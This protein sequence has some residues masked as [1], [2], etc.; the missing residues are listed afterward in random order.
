MTGKILFDV[1]KTCKQSH[2]SGVLRV[3]NC[4]K[5]ELKNALGDRLVEVVWSD[6]KQ[7]FKAPS[8]GSKFS[9][10]PE[11]VFLTAELFSDFE[12]PGI[13]AFL[14]SER[15]RSYA[16]FHDAIP[17]RHPE[18]TWPHSVQ[19]HPSYMK[20]LSRFDGVFAVSAHSSI[21]L[22]EYWEWLG[23]EYAPSVKS[24]QLGANGLFPDP[25][26]SS[27]PLVR[28]FDVLMLGIIEKRKGQDIALDAC[29]RLWDEGLEFNLHVVG[30]ANPYFGKD[31]EKRIK[32]MERNGRPVRLHGH[33]E[34]EALKALMGRMSLML[35]S[36]R[37]EGCGLPV[38]ESLWCGLPVLSSKLA[39]TRETSRFG[40]CCFFNNEDPEA[41]AEQL[42]RL[43]EN[44]H[45]L[46]ELY[47]GIQF[48]LLP[49]WSDT[50]R[51][52]LDTICPEVSSQL[53]ANADH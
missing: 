14:G 7:T 13:E 50:A 33:L 24:I 45:L 52:I 2:Y 18:F 25:I 51:E 48:D 4:L 40:G 10:E 53:P 21:V 37:A 30:R 32:R 49:K 15:C 31:I 6:R 46:V 11:D 36:S 19:R 38:L 20:M 12:R 34:D 1:T 43:F 27:R 22:E 3:S 28:P 29:N 42:K 26:R 9:I 8:Y 5:E 35:F 17:L 44:P 41:M 47:E 39:P 23:Y 16:I